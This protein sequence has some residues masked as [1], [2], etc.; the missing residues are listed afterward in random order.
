MPGDP[1][2]PAILLATYEPGTLSV[3]WQ[4]VQ[5]PG[6]SGFRLFVATP[7]SAPQPFDAGAGEISLQVPI[8]ISQPGTTVSVAALV[9][10]A[11]G[12]QGPA[13][14]VLVEPPVLLLM[15]YDV[16]PSARLLVQWR[17]PL[18]SNVTGYVAVLDELGTSRQ[19][20]VASDQPSAAFAQ[21]LDPAQ[22]YQLTIRATAAD[23]TTQGPVAGPHSPILA[24]AV[25]VLM[26]YD[27][28]PQPVLTA[29]WR[30]PV[31][32]PPAA[33]IAVLRQTG[34][35]NIR[36]QTSTAPAA[37]FGGV[38]ESGSDHV[39][40]VRVTDAAGIIQGPPTPPLTAITEVPQL[41]VLLYDSSPQ[42]TLT[43]RWTAASQPQVQAWVAALSQAG[44]PSWTR[45]TTD[46]TAR[47]EQALDPSQSY[48]ITVRATEATGLV[49]GP[50]SAPV[51]AV[52]ATPQLT[53]LDYDGGI[54]SASW[55]QPAGAGIGGY[56]FFL[57][58]NGG[59]PAAHPAGNDDHIAVS[60]TLDPGSAYAATVR[61]TDAAG[62]AAG[63]AST[64]LAPLT[65]SPGQPKVKFT[66][67]RLVA[68]W[69][70]D[71]HPEVTGY[72]AR[73]VKNGA[74]TP[75][76][77]VTGPSATFEDSLDANVIYGC[78]ARSTG[79]RVKG[80]WGPAGPG[81]YRRRAVTTYDGFG[82]L[83]ALA[84]A[85]GGTLAYGYDD[86]GNILSVSTTGETGGR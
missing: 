58:Q 29:Q 53:G 48:S 62:I 56:T 36:S 76:A 47:F 73:L 75:A 74:P 43:A 71:T 25:M 28:A 52:L 64:P 80:P 65:S 60:G 70:A 79:D 13:V 16:V 63:P 18:D 8:Q 9:N 6:L 10:G 41:Q 59:A 22:S 57:A 45:A 78:Q 72:E 7:G 66:G 1:P 49:Q 24:A 81:P 86:L 68:G 30:A 83:T 77:A 42:P 12:P 69:A 82:R 32:P 51:S 67:S 2:A 20:S 54:L 23:G 37:A 33:Y 21:V 46:P 39:L 14:P 38:L 17:A 31:G 19:W 34:T 55:T 84:F 85:G 3:M 40:T 50:P 35:P 5:P 15:S 44:G 27:T 11:A 61:A 4:P 26:T